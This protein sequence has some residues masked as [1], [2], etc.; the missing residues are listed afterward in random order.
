MPGFDVPTK[1]QLL[2][3]CNAIEAVLGA[4]RDH[5]SFT[6][7]NTPRILTQVK[8]LF[9]ALQRLEEDETRARGAFYTADARARHNLAGLLTACPVVAS[10]LKKRISSKTL[11]HND[12]LGTELMSLTEDIEQFMKS[13]RRQCQPTG[14]PNSGM[15]SESSELVEALLQKQQKHEA[16]VE[17]LGV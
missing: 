2:E 1:A 10:R 8:A 17:A 11:R 3:S 16:E 12:D 6:A 14:R 7:N 4:L 13:W 15:P 9:T 5:T